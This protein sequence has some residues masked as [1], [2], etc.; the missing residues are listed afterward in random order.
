MGIFSFLKKRKQRRS[1]PQDLPPSSRPLPPYCP[2]CGCAVP[3]DA[4][5]CCPNCGYMLIPTRHPGQDKPVQVLY[6]CPNARGLDRS[7]LQRTVTVT[8][9]A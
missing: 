1:A 9:Y 6:G 7:D 4:E 5:I 8:D 3:K 2:V